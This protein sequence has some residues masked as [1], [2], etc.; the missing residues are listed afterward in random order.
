MLHKIGCLAWRGICTCEDISPINRELSKVR[1]ENERLKKENEL[2]KSVSLF[3]FPND[4][5]K[6]SEENEKLKSLVNKL[7]DKILTGSIYVEDKEISV[8][9]TLNRLADRVGL[10]EKRLDGFTEKQRPVEVSVRWPE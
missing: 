10:L 8:D 2:L 5:T 9:E 7:Q 1:A 6:L 4:Y 3:N